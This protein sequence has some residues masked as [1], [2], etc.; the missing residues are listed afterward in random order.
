[1]NFRSFSLFS[2]ACA[3]ILIGL[4]GA[5]SSQT[6][7]GP[8]L[9]LLSKDAR[10]TIPLT[11]ANDQETVA[12]DDLASA[13]QLSVQESLGAITIGYKGR[14][15]LLTPD[16]SLASV[17]GRLVS[18]PSPPVRSGRRWLVPVEF[19]SRALAPMY[20]T[21]LDFRKPSHL[22]VIGDLRVP[23]ISVRYEPQ[24]GS[25]R[26]TIDATPRAESSV[27][28]DNQRLLVKFD[29]DAI[30]APG[31][32]L[33]PQPPQN[34]VQAIRVVDATTIAVDLAA[35]VGGFKATSQPSESASRQVIE[36][37]GPADTTIAAPTTPPGPG[38]PPQPPELP[39]SLGAPVSP[40][41]TIAIDPGHGGEDEGAKGA[42][43]T[44]EKDLALAVA[45]RARSA[46]E[47]RLGIRV[48]LTREDDRNVGLEERT[49]IA[50]NNKAD[51]FISLHANASLR[52]ST[53][54]ATILCAS[55]G[56][57]EALSTAPGSAERVPTF[58]GGLRDIELVPWDLAQTRHIDQSRA[59]AELL[60]RH[61]T[62]HVPLAA[63]PVGRAPLRVLESANMPAVLIELGYLTNADQEKMLASDS[64]QNTFVQ[65]LYDAIVH[66][67]EF[68]GA[69]ATQ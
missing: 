58:G 18:L 30:D 36:L 66:F 59:F 50:N 32:L 9:T 56:A 52:R 57:N 29:A 42:N 16:Q 61:L 62:D 68:L 19:I 13:F 33:P 40:I 22:L 5:L 8:T 6:A 38:A 1:M 53:I 65:A 20:D 14:T 26:L 45:R 37:L 47:A 46:I 28:Q 4:G 67:R 21:R 51:L 69:G 10:R 60:E 43:G 27:S 55:F 34:L 17:S 64:F 15:I 12:L 11:I 49:A 25:G 35:K 39:P 31:P 2:A 54:G 24:A 23:R 63:T 44:K 3:A 41:R 7:S 48:I